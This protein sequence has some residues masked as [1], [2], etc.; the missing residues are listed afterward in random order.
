MKKKLFVYACICIPVLCFCLFFWITYNSTPQKLKIDDDKKIVCFYVWV[1]TGSYK[2]TLQPI[3]KMLNGRDYLYRF[4]I[5]D[6]DVERFPASA[7]EDIG[8]GTPYITYR[9]R[10]IDDY[11]A[12][13]GLVGQEI[14]LNHLS[15]PQIQL[16]RMPRMLE[17]NEYLIVSEGPDILNDPSIPHGGVYF[18]IDEIDGIEYVYPYI[19]DCSSLENSLEITDLGEAMIYK[20]TTDW[21]VIEYIELVHILFRAVY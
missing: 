10:I 5:L 15:N 13:T 20:P 6:D 17:N 9:V 3:T 14:T 19:V 1:D 7:D 18:M 16:Y 8:L 11:G 12:N 21:D 2:R 4:V